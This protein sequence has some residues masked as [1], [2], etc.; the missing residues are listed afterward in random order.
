MFGPNIKGT[1]SIPVN[2]GYAGSK[3]IAGSIE[4]RV[5][6]NCPAT[7]TLSKSAIYGKSTTVQPAALRVM[8]CIKI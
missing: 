1:V 6:S 2:A 3:T 7:L 8:P 5:D 4:N